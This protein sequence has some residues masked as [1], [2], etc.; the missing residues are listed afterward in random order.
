MCI[1]LPGNRTKRVYNSIILQKERELLLDI[2]T[3]C[4]Y[5]TSFQSTDTIMI[6]I[7]IVYYWSDIIFYCKY[8]ISIRQE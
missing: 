3:P 1:I 4:L 7:N 5:I 6:T 8:K 2:T